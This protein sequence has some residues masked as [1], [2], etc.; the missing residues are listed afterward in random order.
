V[1]SVGAVLLASL[2]VSAF[3]AE[4]GLAANESV[5][6]FMIVG[7]ETNQPIGHFEFCR[8]RPA[9]CDVRSGE[10]GPVQLSERLWDQL[11]EINSFVNAAITPATDLEIFGTPEVWFYPSVLGDCEDYALL[12]RRILIENGWPVSALLITVVRKQDGEGHAVLT[13]RTDRGDLVLDNLA[14]E[15][16]VW[17]E[18]PYFYLKRQSDRN[19]GRWVTIDDLR[20]ADEI[21]LVGR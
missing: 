2:A 11:V 6:P 13:V 19:S 7:A 10:T 12:K 4:A 20:G 17:S 14:A 21:R 16:R 3:F 15:I 8:T 1:R 9:E 18:T 5:A